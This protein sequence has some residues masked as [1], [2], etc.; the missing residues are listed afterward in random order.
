MIKN[1]GLF[2]YSPVHF[3]NWFVHDV[4]PGGL[5]GCRAIVSRIS[6]EMPTTTILYSEHH[7]YLF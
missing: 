4:T 2:K 1:T 7:I 6:P 3:W 5:Q